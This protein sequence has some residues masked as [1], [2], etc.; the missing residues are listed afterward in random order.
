MSTGRVA[1][2]SATGQ[3]VDGAGVAVAT[4]GH[5]ALRRVAGLARFHHR[6]AARRRTVVVDQGIAPCRA[7]AVAVRARDDDLVG[8][9]R[10][11]VGGAAGELVDGAAVAVITGG[12][13]DT[14][15]VAGLARFHHRVAARRRTIV[16]D[17][18]IAA[19]RATAVCVSADDDRLIGAGRI[20]VG[21]AAGQRV[22][23]AGVA[24]IAGGRT[25]TG[26]V[27]GLAGLHH[28]VAARRRAIVVCIGVAAGRAAAVRIKAGNDRVVF[29]SRV[30]GLG[31]THQRVGSAVV[32]VVAG[33]R[34]APGR[35]AGLSRFD[36][37]VAAGRTRDRHLYALR[38]H[39]DRGAAAV[40]G[41]DVVQVLP[42][43]HTDS[44]GVAQD[45][46]IREAVGNR[47]VEKELDV[48]PTRRLVVQSSGHGERPDRTFRYR[49]RVPGIVPVDEHARSC[50]GI[51]IPDRTGLGIGSAG[52]SQRRDAVVRNDAVVEHEVKDRVTA[53]VDQVALARAVEVPHPHLCLIYLRLRVLGQHPAGAV[54]GAALEQKGVGTVSN[55][56]PDPHPPAFRVA[57]GKLVT[58]QVGD[59]HR[60]RQRGAYHDAARRGHL[61]RGG[62]VLQQVQG[63]VSRRDVGVGAGEVGILQAQHLWYPGVAARHLVDGQVPGVVVLRLIA[64]VRRIHRRV[65]HMAVL[66]GQKILGALLSE[67]A[68]HPLAVGPLDGKRDAG[69]DPVVDEVEQRTGH[70]VAVA[71]DQPLLVIGRVNP[72][73]VRLEVTVR[74]IVVRSAATRL[75]AA[76]AALVVDPELTVLDVEGLLAGGRREVGHHAVTE[77]AGQ[78]GKVLVDLV[79]LSLKQA[80]V[81]AAAG[82]L[83]AA[84]QPA[85]GC[86]TAQ[87]EVAH[88]AEIVVGHVQRGPEEWI[89]AGAR[90]QASGPGVIGL[91]M[92]DRVVVAV[93]TRAVARRLHRLGER[94]LRPLVGQRPGR[95][96]GREQR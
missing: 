95:G 51:A 77:V 71:A 3:L 88:P 73:V 34:T 28:R 76:T 6:V 10:V 26:R 31:R 78:P 63:R 87:A 54:V 81:H 61:D 20:A 15:R 50:L 45:A 69:V 91:D 19:G 75:A 93:A 74:R 48:V 5:A 22:R 82:R 16:V 32:A 85:G 42:P 18:G 86:V 52:E 83:G 25:D 27:A 9:G 55:L 94:G 17:Q 21:S 4:I 35:I 40:G 37:V 2:G 41:P 68:E 96:R 23:G 65:R 47:L 92:V 12:G 72:G 43:T 59:P 46:V 1:V 44:A 14:W 13:T 70:V 60:Y 66:T 79:Y 39:L 89:A 38:A 80:A 57:G 58:A 56:H 29:A 67:V 8:T 36:D 53:G 30:A 49:K 64:G 62:Q 90:H 84:L 24:V 7:A 33:G 11:A